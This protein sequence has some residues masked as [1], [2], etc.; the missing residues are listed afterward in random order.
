MKNNI[1]KF[2]DALDLL[3][4]EIEYCSSEDHAIEIIQNSG[5]IQAN[6]S[7]K[8]FEDMI[9]YG[10]LSKDID[11]D[12]E[13]V[14][15]K[16]IRLFV[17]LIVFLLFMSAVAIGIMIAGTLLES[18]IYFFSSKIFGIFS[19]LAVGVSCSYIAI[20]VLIFLVDISPLGS[21]ILSPHNKIKTATIIIRR[22]FND[23]I[24]IA[25]FCYIALCL[26]C[27]FN[28]FFAK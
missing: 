12:N 27:L 18:N 10:E 14:I 9:E 15:Q 1:G 3:K 24:Q 19:S 7:K 8:F 23:N 22:V 11:D 17:F 28:A 25:G 20:M 6:Y 2:I 13:S 5:F 26:M 21:N 4:N 16:T